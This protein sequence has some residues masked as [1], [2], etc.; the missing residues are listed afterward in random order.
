MAI[1]HPH[2][3]LQQSGDACCALLSSPPFFPKYQAI[4]QGSAI[5]LTD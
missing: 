1:L 2:E 5:A 3:W 4:F